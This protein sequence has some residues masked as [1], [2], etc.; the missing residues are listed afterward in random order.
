M[1]LAKFRIYMSKTRPRHADTG[2]SRSTCVTILA[3][4]GFRE[5]QVCQRLRLTPGCRVATCKCLVNFLYS[6]VEAGSCAAPVSLAP[7]AD[8]APH[9]VGRVKASAVAQALSQARRHRGRG[10][11]A[12]DLYQV[13]GIPLLDEEQSAHH[14]TQKKAKG[15]KG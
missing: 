3:N 1:T 12:E 15:I 14:G 10:K 9:L 6:D 2:L 11:R 5:A 13:L 8:V 7:P 4:L